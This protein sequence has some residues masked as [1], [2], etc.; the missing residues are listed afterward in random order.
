MGKIIVKLTIAVTLLL[1]GAAQLCMAQTPGPAAG[2]GEP[3]WYVGVLGGT[4][5]GQCTFRSIT[6]YNV[7]W[8]AQGGVFGGYRINRLL[9]V[10]AGLQLGTQAQGALDCCTYWLSEDGTRY[11]SP[12]LDETGWYYHDMTNRTGWGCL[13]LQANADLLSLCTDPDCRWSLNVSPQIA[14][15]TTKTRLMTPDKELQYDRQWHLGLG[16]QVSVGCRITER[17]G[18]SLYEGIT[19]LTGERFD[20]LPQHAHKSNLIWD[21]GVKLSFNL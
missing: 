8:G 14:A 15:V 1:A 20:N 6:E 12:V 10:E 9:S 18:A 17:I 16:G 4:S 21:A 5:F 2:G 3:Q 19:C 7:H 11:M 13:A